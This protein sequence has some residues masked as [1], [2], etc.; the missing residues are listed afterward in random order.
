[1][2]KRAEWTIE[3]GGRLRR[4]ELFHGDLTQLG[5]PDAIDVLV[6]S[7]FPNDY[8]PTPTSLIGAL[9][10]VGISI[11]QLSRYKEAD[12]RAE[13]AC[14]LS[15][16]VELNGR[17]L[18]ILCVESGWRGSPPEIADDLFRALATT[19]ILGF[20]EASVAMPLIG[21]G[22]QGWSTATMMSSILN[23]AVSWFR[24]GLALRSVRIVARSPRSADA[25]QEMFE[26]AKTADA[27]NEPSSRGR[28][29]VFI[30]Y[31]HADRPAAQEAID[32]LLAVRPQLRVFYDDRSINPGSSWL[33]E[34]AESLDNSRRVL[35]LY[36]PP[37]WESRYCKDEF[38][39]AYTREKDTGQAVL[40][41]VYV[42]SANIPY[43]FRTIQHQDC[44]ESDGAKLAAACRALSKSL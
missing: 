6:V 3:H 25:A 2:E 5:P 34:I 17:P 20:E 12:L 24:R 33:L 29:D 42:R 7:A 11:E 1:M 10:R 19:P 40:Y 4:I 32:T 36:T 13:F 39:A 44:R 27:V 9:A 8:L 35:A 26:A 30:S 37:Y 16:P 23:S 31:A 22:D 38:V 41:P 21:A 18:R 43:L 14:W 15:R 28:Y